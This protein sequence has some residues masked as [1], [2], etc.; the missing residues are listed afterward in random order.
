MQDHKLAFFFRDAL[1]IAFGV[2]IAAYVLGENRI[3]YDNFLSLFGVA[4]VISLLNAFLRPVMIT[5][6]LPILIS[7]FGLGSGLRA[8]LNPR[9]LVGAILAFVGATALLLWFI[10]ACIFKLAD[11]IAGS[12]FVVNGFG[13]AMLG[14]IFTSCA[15][16]FIFVIFGIKRQSVIS[17]I[18]HNINFTATTNPPNSDNSEQAH[19]PPPQQR[20]RD[21]NDNDVIDI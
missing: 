16:L 7:T 6:A 15:T 11:V 13:S 17:Q 21:K 2:L 14:S 4:I 19:R 20:R 12:S 3:H 5:F 8:L 9:S 1:I 10:N 18:F